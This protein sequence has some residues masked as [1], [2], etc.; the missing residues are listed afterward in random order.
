MDTEK[1]N[2]DYLLWRSLSSTYRRINYTLEKPLKRL[3][4]TSDTEGILNLVFMLNNCASP[5]Q[6]G[7][8]A[9]R[10][11]QTITSRLNVMIKKGLLVKT[12]NDFKRNT[13]RVSMTEKGEQV[14]QKS[15][16]LKRYSQIMGVLPEEKRRIFEECLMALREHSKN[17]K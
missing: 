15:R 2:P 3:G 8:M 16:T 4:L 17:L 14:F 5:T 10:K 9:L 6:I 12:R 1:S 11:P 13:F 7:R